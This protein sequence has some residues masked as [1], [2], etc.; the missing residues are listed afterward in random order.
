[1][2]LFSRK[3][4]YRTSSLGNLYW[5][6]EHDVSRDDWYRSQGASEGE[7]T[8]YQ[9]SLRML[10]EIEADRSAAS[11]YTKPNAVCPVC[12]QSV[13]F[14]QNRSGSRVYFDD[15][16][17]PWP[18]HPCMDFPAF[19]GDDASRRSG[20]CASPVLRAAIEIQVIEDLL[21]TSWR[22]TQREFWEKYGVSQWDAFK[23]VKR[24]RAGKRT[25][26][27]L[28]GI[29]YLAPRRIFLIGEKTPQAIREGI[30]I[31]YYRGWVSFFDPQ[32]M[33]P[34]DHELGRLSG[35]SAFVE[36]LLG[37]K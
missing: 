4:H 5:V 32:K 1:M 12:G 17:K 8:K 21:E 2:T 31:Y 27:I 29:S 33:E 10:Q 35:P 23:V 36:A 19:A 11:A 30:L 34:V 24:L 9:E 18:K 22:D 25:L 26:L 15:L 7:Y 16:G 28:D 6:G 20:E 37:L 13:F 14:Y 3:G